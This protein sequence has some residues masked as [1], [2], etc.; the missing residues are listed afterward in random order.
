[1]SYIELKYAPRKC[2]AFCM[3]DCMLTENKSC[4][5]YMNTCAKGFIYTFILKPLG[6]SLRWV[7]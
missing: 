1:M 4:G 3:G 5:K 2:S 6:G 7:K